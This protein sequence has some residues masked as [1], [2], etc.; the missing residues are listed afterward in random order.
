MKKNGS[1]MNIMCPLGHVLGESLGVA[2]LGLK[3]WAGH[4]PTD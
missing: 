4:E 3:H 1:V 2:A